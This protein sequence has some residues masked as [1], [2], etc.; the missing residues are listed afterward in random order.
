MV[1]VVCDP[2]AQHNR[3]AKF[4]LHRDTQSMY[5]SRNSGDFINPRPPPFKPTSI[6][7]FSFSSGSRPLD[8]AVHPPLV[9]TKEGEKLL[10]IAFYG[11]VGRSRL[12][13]FEG[14]EG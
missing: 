8:V 4:T 9:E 14:E 10:V 6:Y 7:H 5:S 2:F 1:G 3:M 12:F 11:V 13:L